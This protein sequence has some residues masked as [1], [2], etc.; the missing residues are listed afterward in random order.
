MTVFSLTPFDRLLHKFKPKEQSKKPPAS[1][2]LVGQEIFY[3]FHNR[4]RPGR[5]TLEKTLLCSQFSLV[6]SQR[7]PESQLEEILSHYLENV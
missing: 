1:N 2:L 7:K 5:S 4:Y 6:L 3:I